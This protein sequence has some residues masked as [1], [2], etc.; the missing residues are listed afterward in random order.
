[1]IYLEYGGMVDGYIRTG[2]GEEVTV[3]GYAVNVGE[4]HHFALSFD[5]ASRSLTLYEDGNVYSSTQPGTAHY[6]LAGQTFYVGGSPDQPSS[7]IIDDVRFFDTALDQPAIQTWMSTPVS[8]GTSDESSNPTI[9]VGG[10][11]TG[12]HWSVMK[13]GVET[14]VTSWSIMKNGVETPLADPSAT[15]H[16]VFGDQAPSYTLAVYADGAPNITVGNYFYAYGDSSVNWQCVGGRVYVPN[17]PNLVGKNI[18]IEAWYLGGWAVD[19]TTAPLRSVQ[20]TVPATGGW[21]AVSWSGFAIPVGSVAF[22][23]YTFEASVDDYYIA[24]S[25]ASVG[26]NFVT[27]SDGASIVLAESTMSQPFAAQRGAYL[28]GTSTS[29]G[30]ANWYGTDIVADTA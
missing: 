24:A 21:T 4:W 10:I 28:M 8:S 5:D 15:T 2:M 25:G 19:L 7:M 3:N 22:I 23:G 29:G 16:T 30:T 6:D 1:M 11:E 17:D 26:S 18:T 13:N 14:P 12:V 20:T 9:M 27:A